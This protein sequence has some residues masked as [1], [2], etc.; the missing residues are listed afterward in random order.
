[1]LF[2]DVLT[3]SSDDFADDIIKKLKK[4]YKVP[5]SIIIPL[6]EPKVIII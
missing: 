1:M 6:P 2:S 5:A 3:I 4:K